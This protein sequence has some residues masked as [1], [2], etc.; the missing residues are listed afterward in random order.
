MLDNKNLVDKIYAK[1]SVMSKGQK[2]V[3][4]FL[5]DHY[6]KA[7]YLTASRLAKTI[8]VSESTVVRFAY[9]LGFEGYPQLRVALEEL[10]KTKLTATQRVEVSLNRVFNNE[11]SVLKAVLQND[12]ERIAATIEG[13]NQNIFDVVVNAIVNAK[14]IYI[15]GERSVSPLASFLSF[16]LNLMVENVI[17]TNSNSA[18]EVFEQIFRISEDDLCICI[19]FPRYS[20]KTVKAMEYAKEKNAVTVA[21]TDSIN[22]PIASIAAHN[23]IAR[24][25]MISFIDSLVAP[26]SVINAI[27]VAVSLKKQGDLVHTLDK[28][29]NMWNEYQ[30]YSSNTEYKYINLERDKE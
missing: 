21:I 23:L 13:I 14:K 2:R 5:I 24:S 4:D 16:Y 29:E 30:V 17:N 11:K 26:M 12:A 9:E 3:A 6:D 19:S 20:Q 8:G 18:S 25:D 28:L 7:V 22:S 1:Q 10:V 15:V 27:L